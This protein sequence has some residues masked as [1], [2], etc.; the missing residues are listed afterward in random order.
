ML[1]NQWRWSAP[2]AR[3]STQS[4]QQINFHWF[5][6]IYLRKRKQLAIEDTYQNCQGMNS[7]GERPAHLLK[8]MMIRIAV[9]SRLRIE[10]RSGRGD[11]VTKQKKNNHFHQ[12]QFQLQKTLEAKLLFYILFWPFGAE[13]Q[14]GNNTDWLIRQW[15][16]RDVTN[17][18]HQLSSCKITQLFRVFELPNLRFSAQLSWIAMKRFNLA[19]L[20]GFPAFYSCFFHTVEKVFLGASASRDVV[21]TQ[22]GHYS[23]FK[24]WRSSWWLV[25]HWY[26]IWT[27]RKSDA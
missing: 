20:L 14:A 17:S 6:E 9:K 21:V 25:K 15:L 24:T 23:S 4:S 13:E 27:H 16:L 26:L 22:F 5:I 3:A 18:V 1:C 19:V 10:L 11:D 8:K 7:T 2:T 12:T